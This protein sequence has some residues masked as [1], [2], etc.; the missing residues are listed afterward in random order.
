M[1]DGDVGWGLGDEDGGWD[2]GGVRIGWGWERMLKIIASDL[3]VLPVFWIASCLFTECGSKSLCSQG[4]AGPIV[5]IVPP[6]QK[7]LMEST[8]PHQE[9]LLRSWDVSHRQLFSPDLCP[10][11]HDE[12]QLFGG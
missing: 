5:P 1:G 4:S 7:S 10:I 11:P 3:Q 9:P 6:T 2:G 12:A 8:G